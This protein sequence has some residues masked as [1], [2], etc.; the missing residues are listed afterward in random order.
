MF[1]TSVLCTRYIG[2]DGLILTVSSTGRKKVNH[3][4]LNSKGYYMIRK[5]KLGTGVHRVVAEAFLPNPENKEQVNHI[6]GI[7]VDNRVENLE[8]VTSSENQKHSYA[9]GLRKPVMMIGADNPAYGKRGALN[10]NYHSEVY[11]FTHKSGMVRNC[12]KRELITEFGLYD[13]NL[14]AVVKGRLKTTGGWSVEI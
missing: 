10:Q 9:L 8:W 5:G 1:H 4:Q 13:S 11:K 2:R 7:K 12:T 6:N 14:F 3:G